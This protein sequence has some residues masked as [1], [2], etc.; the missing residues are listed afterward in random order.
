MVTVILRWQQLSLWSEASSTHSYSYYLTCTTIS[1]VLQEKSLFL[2]SDFWPVQQF[3]LLYSKNHYYYLQRLLL[4]VNTDFCCI[5]VEIVIHVSSFDKYNQVKVMII[6]VRVG[7]F[8]HLLLLII[9][10]LCV[11]LAE[12]INENCCYLKITISISLW[13]KAEILL[14]DMAHFGKQCHKRNIETT[15]WIWIFKTNLNKHLP[16]MIV[17]G[18]GLQGEI[19]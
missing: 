14:Q 1:T 3:P 17:W 6:V 2:P 12:D 19:L 4:V 13:S 9:M 8:D 16:I 11:E 15:G 10:G 5:A 18:T 7:S